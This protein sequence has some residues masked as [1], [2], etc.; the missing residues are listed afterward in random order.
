MSLFINQSFICP[1]LMNK[2]F[3]FHRECFVTLD[4]MEVAKKFKL[5]IN[6]TFSEKGGVFWQGVN[7][8][9]LTRYLMALIQ[10]FVIN[11]GKELL[12][13]LRTGRQQNMRKVNNLGEFVNDEDAPESC[14]VKDDHDSST[15]ILN[16]K[17]QVNVGKTFLQ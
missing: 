1:V 9:Q 13:T 10:D 8:E 7:D 2:C 6:R 4:E 14:E 17:L 15:Y 5:A 12:G 16:E 3:Y 11:D